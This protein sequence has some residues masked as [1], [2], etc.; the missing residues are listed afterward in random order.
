[1]FLGGEWV[2]GWVR[3]AQTCGY[4]RACTVAHGYFLRIC[5]VAHGEI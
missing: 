4:S 3:H 5:T 1:M 2:G